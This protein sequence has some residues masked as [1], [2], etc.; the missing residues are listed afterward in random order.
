[1]ILAP[2]A[3]AVEAAFATLASDQLELFHSTTG[4]MPVGVIEAVL[5]HD[6][7]PPGNPRDW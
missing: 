5:V 3:R 7:I 1:V 2:Y 4:P 6:E